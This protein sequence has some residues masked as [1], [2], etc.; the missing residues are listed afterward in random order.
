[1]SD[2]TEDPTPRRLRKA[3]EAGDA[4]ASV[5]AAQAVSFVV[6]AALWP[7]AVRAT[8][9][10]TSGW[11]RAVLAAPQGR[12]PRVDPI[13]MAGE[14]L[15]LVAPLLAAVAATSAL[16][17]VLQTQGVIS[18]KKLSPDLGRLD[19]MAGLRN[20]FSGAR[21]FAVVRALAAGAVVGWLAVTGI[22]DHASE[23]AHTLGRPR[24]VA[25]LVA[26]LVGTLVWRSALVGLVLAVADVAFTRRAWLRRLRMTKAEVKREHRDAEGDPQ[27]KAARERAHHELLTQA[28]LASVKGASVVVINPTHLAC[29]LR[30]N[31]YDAYGDA[32]APV[33]VASGAGDAAARIVRAANDYGVPI[34]RDVPLARALAELAIGDAIPEALFQAVAAVLTEVWAADGAPA[35]P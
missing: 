1:V 33:V 34:V 20:L 14:V 5:Y 6:A 8:A 17:Q 30:Y 25:P 22:A 31:A 2:K 32:H 35:P 29:A 28:S 9:E 10:R 3:R 13:V 4:G 23:L 27:L 15:R 16:V 18:A 24:W 19:P 7:S 12:P 21:A 26:S 11:L